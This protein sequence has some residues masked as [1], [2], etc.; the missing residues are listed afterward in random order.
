MTKTGRTVSLA[1]ELGA[2]TLWEEKTNEGR[3]TSPGIYQKISLQNLL[4]LQYFNQAIRYFNEDNPLAAYQ[5]A[6][7]ALKY[8]NSDRIRVF[9]DFL[10]Q[11]LALASR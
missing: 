7:T 5:F 6:V 1:F 3:S 9:S 2:R 8:H 11:Q 4:G 10:K